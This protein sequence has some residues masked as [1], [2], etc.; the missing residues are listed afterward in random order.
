MPEISKQMRGTRSRC[1]SIIDNRFQIIINWIRRRTFHSNHSNNY[2]RRHHNLKHA[3]I[4]KEQS[5][6]PNFVLLDWNTQFNS[7][8]GSVG[9]FISPLPIIHRSPGEEE[10]ES[11]VS[12]WIFFCT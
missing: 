7:K 2:P 9:D 10:I 1:H 12:C 6:L 11:N 3:C 4:C 8:S 5:A